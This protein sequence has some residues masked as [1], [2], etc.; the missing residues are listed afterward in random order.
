TIICTLRSILP[1]KNVWIVI[2]IMGHGYNRA[3]WKPD[4]PGLRRRGYARVG[5]V[6]RIG[7]LAGLSANSGTVEGIPIIV[8]CANLLLWASGVCARWKLPFEVR[9][10]LTEQ[11]MYCTALAL[12][13]EA[14]IGCS[15]T[16]VG[17]GV[18]SAESDLPPKSCRPEPMNVSRAG[19]IGEIR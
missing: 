3:V 16:R 8:R 13:V 7:K 11:S 5:M 15:P 12:E 1:V 10:P 14:D 6:R 2:P 4:R 19:Q 9:L 18:D 17:R